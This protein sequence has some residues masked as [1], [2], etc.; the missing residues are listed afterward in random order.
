M[1]ED[2]ASDKDATATGADTADLTDA[3]A[4]EETA[5]ETTGAAE[6]GALT[7]AE[8]AAVPREAKKKYTSVRSSATAA[9]ANPTTAIPKIRTD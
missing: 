7:G 8:A 2:S 4:T 9:Q 6:K 1:T 3:T 5:E